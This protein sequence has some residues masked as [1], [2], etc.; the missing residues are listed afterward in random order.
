MKLDKKHS[1]F[2]RGISNSSR[3]GML[4]GSLKVLPVEARELVPA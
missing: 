3:N 4:A 1:M 2:V